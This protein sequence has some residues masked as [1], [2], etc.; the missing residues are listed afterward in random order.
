MENSEDISSNLQ[1]NIASYDGI[2]L[3]RQKY[4][5]YSDSW[6]HDHCEICGNK[7]MEVASEDAEDE[8]YSTE[9][10]YNW[11][12]LACVKKYDKFAKWILNK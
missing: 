6:D 2:V 12:C 11:F 5:R 9:D 7:L 8:G 4:T 10:R 1:E 3:I